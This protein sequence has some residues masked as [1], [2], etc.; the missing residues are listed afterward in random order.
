MASYIDASSTPW[1]RSKIDEM[2]ETLNGDWHYVSSPEEL[3]VIKAT[4]RLHQGALLWAGQ[5]HRKASH[6]LRPVQPL[7]G[8]TKAAGNRIGGP[9]DR[10]DSNRSPGDDQMRPSQAT[11]CLAWTQ[12][13]GYPSLKAV[14]S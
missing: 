7:D 12:K 14:L 13:R 1:H 10:Q 9:D 4:V 5:E 2:S 3:G 11:K 6:P 8:A